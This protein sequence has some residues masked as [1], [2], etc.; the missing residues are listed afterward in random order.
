MKRACRRIAPTTWRRRL[1]AMTELLRNA[2]IVT[3][4]NTLARLKAEVA[5]R[6]TRNESEL[7]RIKA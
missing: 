6:K 4:P 7:I 5:T 3:D 2:S 1:L